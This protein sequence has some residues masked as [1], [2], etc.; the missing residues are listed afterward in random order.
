MFQYSA[1]AP[2]SKTAILWVWK[3]SWNGF[4]L[5]RVGL[6]DGDGHC[7]SSE[8]ENE[9]ANDT[10]SREEFSLSMSTLPIEISHISFRE[11]YITFYSSLLL[12]FQVFGQMGSGSGCDK[13]FSK[14]FDMEKQWDDEG[15]VKAL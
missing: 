8:K 6:C 7:E 10:H 2:T 5:F 12:D 4:K 11:S 15:I 1:G 13:V 9:G 14:C 3:V